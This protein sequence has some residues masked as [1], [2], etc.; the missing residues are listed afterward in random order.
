M[1]DISYDAVEES[2]T[3]HLLAKLSFEILNE[4]SALNAHGDHDPLVDLFIQLL[5]LDRSTNHQADIIR[6]F[7][8]VA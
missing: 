1:I 7:G 2:E 4:E 3:F 8:A 6:A 5:D